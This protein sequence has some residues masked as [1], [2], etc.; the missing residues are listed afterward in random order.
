VYV[1]SGPA[2]SEWQHSIPAVDAVRYSITYRSV[3]AR[4]ARRRR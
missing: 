4:G 3:R 1:L 2:R